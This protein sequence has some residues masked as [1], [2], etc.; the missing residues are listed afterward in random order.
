VIDTSPKNP[1]LL[2]QSL[3]VVDRLLVPVAPRPMDL[4]ELPATFALA[5]EVDVVHPLDVS[6]LLVQVRAR[7]RSGVEARS[8][9]EGMGVPVLVAQTRLSEGLAL[10]FGT[11]PANLGDYGPVLVELL[12]EVTA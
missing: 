6:T 1:V 8:F 4:R 2:K 11:A 9:L 5:A 10:A 7:T 12:A 3:M